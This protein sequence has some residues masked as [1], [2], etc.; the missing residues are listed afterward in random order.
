MNWTRMVNI[1]ILLIGVAATIYYTIADK[2]A[3][4]A[5]VVLLCILY[6]VALPRIT[7]S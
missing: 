2:E 6:F 3:Q 5:L 7:R 1:G 4:G